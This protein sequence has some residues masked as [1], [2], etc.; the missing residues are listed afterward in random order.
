[1][2]Y[3]N[4]VLAKGMITY[5]FLRMSKNLT[6]F[7]VVQKWKNIGT[8]KKCKI[9]WTTELPNQYTIHSNIIFYHTPR[10]IEYC[11]RNLNISGVFSIHF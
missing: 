4:M 7:F 1:M 8:K 6:L 10:L 2:S 3:G 9:T 11:Y 5:D